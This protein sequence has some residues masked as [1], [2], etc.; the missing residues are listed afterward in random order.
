MFWDI[1]VVLAIMSTIFMIPTVLLQVL[2]GIV[3]QD[4]TVASALFGI[5]LTLI[6]WFVT[7]ASYSCAIDY[8]VVRPLL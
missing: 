5:I 4:G 2:L 7:V 1:F 3:K 6:F 8:F